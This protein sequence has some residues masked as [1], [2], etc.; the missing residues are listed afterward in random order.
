[1]KDENAR[2]SVLL[3][4]EYLLARYCKRYHSPKRNTIA[5]IRWE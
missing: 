2:K 1:M 5:G 4:L 3:T